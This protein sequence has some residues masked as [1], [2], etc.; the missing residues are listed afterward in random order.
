MEWYGGPLNHRPPIQGIQ[1]STTCTKG[2]VSSSVKTNVLLSELDARLY[3]NAGAFSDAVLEPL[4]MQTVPPV[5][6][7]EGL[8]DTG[9]KLGLPAVMLILFVWAGLPRIDHA[10][11]VSERLD[12]RMQLVVS[13]CAARIPPSVLSPLP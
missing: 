13:S 12:Q 3:R 1:A 6:T 4:T 10:L 9:A 5:T 2:Q 7:I 11:E 8:V